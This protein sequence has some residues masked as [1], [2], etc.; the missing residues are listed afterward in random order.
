M[1]IA[2][3]LL[4]GIFLVALAHFWLAHQAVKAVRAQIEETDQALARVNALVDSLRARFVDKPLTQQM[5]AAAPVA[6]APLAERMAKVHDML[7]R[8]KGS[9]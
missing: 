6:E 5:P 3:A 7:V 1:T 8:K 9:Q 2:I 4:G